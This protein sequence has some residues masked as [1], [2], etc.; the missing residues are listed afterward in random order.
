MTDPIS[1]ELESVID[2]T[3]ASITGEKLYSSANSNISKQGPDI[4]PQPSQPYI[5][6]AR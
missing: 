1:Y 4:D 2:F 6:F 5:E 3:P